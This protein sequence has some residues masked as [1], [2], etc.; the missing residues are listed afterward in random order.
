M[1]IPSFLRH[2]LAASVLV[3]LVAAASLPA[4]AQT[5]KTVKERGT[6]ACGVSTGVIGFSM[7][8]PSGEWNGFD[9]DF[10]RA[11]AA[12]IFDDANRVKFVPLNAAERFQA[13]Q[14]GAV[15]LLSR[16][17]SWTMSREADLGLAFAA[18]TY[19]DGQGFMVPRARKVETALD[20]AG[21]KVC[22]QAGTTSEHNVGDYFKANG[23]A[24]QL[25]AKPAM[26]DV[27]KAYD[28]G[29][30]DV[31]TSDASALHGERLKLTKP[32]DHV[33]L[34]D[35]IS[36]EPLGPAV[37]GNDPQWLA[38]VK[39]AHFAMVN[40]EELGV[41]QKTIEAALKSSKP[42]VRDL[43][44]LDGGGEKFGLT[45]DWAVRIVRLVGNYSEVYERNLGTKTQLGIPRGLNQ[46]W[47]AGGIMYAPPVR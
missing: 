12:A 8:S 39:W 35:V 21:S 25:I 47:T 45:R 15:D 6:L 46:L 11:V 31:M 28:A 26:V 7:Q 17:S 38:V 10:C 23:M 44:G 36:K 24:F 33:I 29:E 40:A 5:L 1:R 3:P 18:V 20:L 43:V 4:A 27:E 42:Q 37:R 2:A 34:A 32:A 30:C 13:L 19:H 16:N 41:G 9:V 14:S 22:V